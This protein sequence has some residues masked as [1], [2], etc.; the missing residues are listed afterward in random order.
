MLREEWNNRYQVKEEWWKVDCSCLKIF[1]CYSKIK[2]KICHN[3]CLNRVS[4]LTTV[5]RPEKR[6]HKKDV[7][8][9]IRLRLPRSQKS[10]DNQNEMHKCE[11]LK[12]VKDIVL[13]S[14]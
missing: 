6:N 3:Y 9:D 7:V 2:N 1:L 13:Q 5:N 14:F 4:W 10:V 8:K 11:N 12:Y